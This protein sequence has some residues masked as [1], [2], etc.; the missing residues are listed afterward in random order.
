M[1]RGIPQIKFSQDGPTQCGWSCRRGG[2]KA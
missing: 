2:G 1:V